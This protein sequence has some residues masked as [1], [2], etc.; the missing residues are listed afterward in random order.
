[1]YE[2][3]GD[4]YNYEKGEYAT[5][6]LKWKDTE[7]ILE[8][9][10]RKG[11]FTGMKEERILNITVVNSQQGTGTQV[12]TPIRTVTYSGKLIQIKI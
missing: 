9:S 12:A 6:E 7:K 8:I 10:E 1:M 11:S 2:D 3:E 5:F 4:N